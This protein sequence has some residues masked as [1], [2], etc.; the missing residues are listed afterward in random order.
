MRLYIL[1][2]NGDNFSKEQKDALKKHYAEIIY[3]GEAMPFSALPQIGDAAE[4][5]LAIEP[6]FCDWNIPNEALDIAGLRAVCLQTTSYGWIDLDYA[7]AKGV[8]V[9]NVRHWSTESVAEQTILMALYLSRKMPLLAQ[10][11]ME[12]DFAKMLGTELAGKTAGIVGLGHIGKRIAGLCQALGMKV[13]YWS[14]QSTDDRFEKAN[15]DALFKTADFIFPALIKNEETEKII[16][17]GLANDLKPSAILCDITGTVAQDHDRLL[18]M[19]KDGKIGGYGFEELHP[20]RYEGNVFAVPPVAYY[21][22]EAMAANTVQWL[23]CIISAT[24]SA[25]KNKLN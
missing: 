16:A 6:E 19:A 8:A 14:R 5:V 24:S 23:E 18:K 21:T 17:K 3:I 1:A 15:L 10:N 7:A 12:I 4:K 13:V 25:L 9:S 11:N 2:P 20:K 22:H